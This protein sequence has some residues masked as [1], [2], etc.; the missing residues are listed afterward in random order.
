[1][2]NRPNQVHQTNVAKYSL[3]GLWCLGELIRC[4][5]IC[6]RGRRH[7]SETTDPCRASAGQHRPFI[8]VSISFTFLFSFFTHSNR[9]LKKNNRHALQKMTRLV[10]DF[11]VLSK[12]ISLVL[13]S[14]QSA[15]SA[16]DSQNRE[17]IP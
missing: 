16:A 7:P 12:L 8:S 17:T 2:L 6:M 3:L 1:M 10:G 13:G 11:W 4:K 14:F 15:Y 9:R 5:L